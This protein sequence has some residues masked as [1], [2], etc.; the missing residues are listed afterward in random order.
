MVGFGYLAIFVLSMLLQY[1]LSMNTSYFA[2]MI[3]LKSARALSNLIYRKLF[4]ISSAT[5]TTFNQGEIVNFVE[6][7]SWRLY[8]LCT[9]LVNVTQL[10]LVLTVSFIF[11]FYYLGISFLAGIGIFVIACAFNFVFGW[12]TANLWTAIM[13][14]RDERMNIVTEVLNNI[15]MIKLYSWSNT[16]KEKIREK[17]QRELKVVAK[18]YVMECFSTTSYI[19]FP[20]MMN[21]VTFIVYIGMGNHLDLSTAF[22]VMVFF[23]VITVND[24]C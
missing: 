16:F 24:Y 22:T 17:R 2:E 19:F 21:I 23:S 6:V 20:T 9:N 13:K 1:I 14:K 7:D 5:N 11:L 10:P 3:G 8:F 15:K 12:M 4:T 18:T